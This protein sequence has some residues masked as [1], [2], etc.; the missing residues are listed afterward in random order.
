MFLVIAQLQQAGNVAAAVE[1]YRDVL[2]VNPTNPDAHHLLGLV[3]LQSGNAETAVQ[4]IGRAVALNPA[5]LAYGIDWGRA[6][7]AA[8][9]TL[10]ARQCL[11]RI[12]CM[13]TRLTARPSPP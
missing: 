2:V 3:A 1:I 9:K 5:E 11:A 8:G 4:L 6:L 10:E 12:T 7:A 13:L